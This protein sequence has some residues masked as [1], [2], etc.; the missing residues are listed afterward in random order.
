MRA[1]PS[2][3]GTA[4]MLKTARLGWK[5]IGIGGPGLGRMP[6]AR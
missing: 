6:V 3:A 4:S 2:E 1:R 5:D